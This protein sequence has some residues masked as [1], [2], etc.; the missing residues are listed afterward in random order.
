MFKKLS[1]T[2]LE[3]MNVIW[4][5]DEPKTFAWIL[6]FFNVHCDK[7]WKRQTLST[8]MTKL[9]GRKLLSVKSV[10][11]STEYTSI[12]SRQEYEAMQAQGVLNNL[13]N[14]SLR[15]FLTALNQGKAVSEEDV[16]DLK[17]WIPEQ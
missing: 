14:G 7:N 16:Q 3:I 15:N 4:E 8:Y 1:D 10:G 12:V 13:Y 11:K 9:V 5:Q 17:K 6:E 2:E